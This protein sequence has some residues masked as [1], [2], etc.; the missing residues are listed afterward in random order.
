MPCII[1]NHKWL[2]EVVHQP[3][4]VVGSTAMKEM[5]KWLMEQDELLMPKT[6]MIIVA[7]A[8]S[9]L[10]TE[11]EQI[12]IAANVCRLHAELGVTKFGQ[13]YYKEAHG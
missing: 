13:D 10:E 3:P 5:I 4:H 11:R 2:K 1:K 6:R 9:L 12:E 7:K 8:D